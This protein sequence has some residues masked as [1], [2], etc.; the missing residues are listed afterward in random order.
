MAEILD[1]LDARA[2]DG[3]APVT[4][5]RGMSPG[6]QHHHISCVETPVAFPRV[7]V[8]QS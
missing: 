5:P 6:A 3:A 8:H 4:N 7:D 1:M 2:W